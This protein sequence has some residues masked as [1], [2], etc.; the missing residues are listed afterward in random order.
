MLPALR[1]DFT[2]VL[3]YYLHLC[4]HFTTLI[5]P[6]CCHFYSAEFKV[7]DNAE[8]A[9]IDLGGLVQAGGAH[10]SR[11][12]YFYVYGNAQ[13]KTITFSRLQAFFGR[14]N[15][16]TAT[17]TTRYRARHSSTFIVRW[18]LPLCAT[19]DSRVWC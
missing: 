8:L 10:C 16:V 18:Y 13:L 15:G 3:A 12:C 11:Y 9:E 17:T 5:A 14:A 1:F 4:V 6:S 2:F 7:Y 19:L